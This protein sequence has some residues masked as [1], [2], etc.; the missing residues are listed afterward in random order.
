MT[1]AAPYGSAAW[2]AWKHDHHWAAGGGAPADPLGAGNTALIGASGLN[3]TPLAFYD[4]RKNLTVASGTASSLAD[5]SGVGTYGPALNQ[6][7]QAA[8]PTWDGTTL[9]F[10]GVNDFMLSASTVTGLDISTIIT[11]VLVADIQTTVTSKTAAAIGASGGVSPFFVIRTVTGPLVQVASSHQSHSST[12]APG[13]GN[14]RLIIA[15]INVAA[16][17][18]VA[19]EIPTAAA[20]NSGSGTA[21]TSG[22]QLIAL[23]AATSGASAFCSIRFRAFLAWAGSYTTGQR[24]TLKTWTTTYH[25]AV[26]V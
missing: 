24:D 9:N 16:T 8:Q 18:S 23:G 7:T 3:V 21:E 11:M 14:I 26:L 2:R 25:G 13:S 20:G 10:D 19:I 1:R 22:N 12:V 15:T 4:V 17:D 6:A 5:V